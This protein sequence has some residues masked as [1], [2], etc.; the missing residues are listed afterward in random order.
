MNGGAGT[1]RADPA[2]GCRVACCEL[3]RR[4]HDATGGRARQSGRC[5]EM[6]NKDRFCAAGH[7]LHRNRRASIL[8]P[9]ATPIVAVARRTRRAHAGRFLFRVT[10]GV[11]E[12]RKARPNAWRLGRTFPSGDQLN[13]R[14]LE[15]CGATVKCSAYSRILRRQRA[16]VAPARGLTALVSVWS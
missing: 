13:T 14:I 6:L 10:V 11:G 2:G 8:R 15:T 1:R 4:A 7:A 12:M 5:S 9:L 16:Q 3:T